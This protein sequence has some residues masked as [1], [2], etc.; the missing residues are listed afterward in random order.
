MKDLMVI[1][2]IDPGI[3]CG[4]AAL[5]LDGA[6]VFIESRRNWNSSDLIQALTEIGELVII[7]S[8]VSPAPELL[9]RL[10]KKLNAILFTPL[11]S[12]G[13]I[14]KHQVAR[15]YTKQYDI[16]LRN[17][18]ERD[19]LAAAVKAYQHYKNK[20]ERI[21]MKVKDLDIQVSADKVKTLV[22]RGYTIKRAIQQLLKPTNELAPRVKRGFSQEERLK[23]LVEE[24]QERLLLEKE[25]S[26]NLRVLNQ[27]LHLQI[28]TLKREI[29]ILQ[30]KIE[31]V[32]SE[33]STQIRRELEYHRLLDE[34]NILR[35]ELSKANARLEDYK[36][37]F[38]QLYYLRELESKGELIFLKPIE[39]F[40]KEGLDKAFKLY[41]I[42]FGDYVIL[43][44]SSGG[45]PSTA[46][47]LAKRG[48]KAIITCKQMAHQARETFIKYAIPLVSA[49]KVKI[50]W[51]EGFP[52]AESLSLKKA[53]NDLD[54]LESLEAIKEIKTII[55]DH[56]K[57][58]KNEEN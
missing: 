2:G 23:R 11:I 12:L 53:I 48:T 56:I 29:S 52:Y 42:K 44:D 6:P 55:E 37:R 35:A 43:L 40:T 54:K 26:K 31:D 28:R 19:A 49:D 32:K 15:L 46:E 33:Q 45:G 50:E 57:E 13:T 21:D 24:L 39:S 41:D 9:E 38:D 27:E 4:V 14:E 20:F 7:S 47:T 58:L 36:K 3:T 18:H 51:I 17:A 8:D 10:S 22:I 34:V 5:R 16:K 1:V 30:G 25:A